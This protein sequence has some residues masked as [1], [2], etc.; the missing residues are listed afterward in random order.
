VGEQLVLIYTNYYIYTNFYLCLYYDDIYTHKQTKHNF[1]ELYRSISNT[2]LFTLTTTTSTNMS[3]GSYA[4][5]SQHRRRLISQID[6][7][8]GT[9]LRRPEN[10]RDSPQYTLLSM[11]HTSDINRMRFNRLY[12]RTFPDGLPPLAPVACQPN[13]ASSQCS[14]TIAQEGKSKEEREGEVEVERDEGSDNA[15]GLYSDPDGGSNSEEDC[16]DVRSDEE[17]EERR[18]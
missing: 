11:I 10:W 14:S 2:H 5:H 1:I 4:L 16:I 3:L 6:P 13:P 12:R 17:E 7:Y 18:C 8:Y 9:G 15:T